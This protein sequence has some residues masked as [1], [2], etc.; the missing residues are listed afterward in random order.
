MDERSES[1]IGACGGI[2]R[3]E[4]DIELAGGIGARHLENG[5]NSEAR[6]AVTVG[7]VC[8]RWSPT[9]RSQA[10]V[11]GRGGRCD[12]A[13]GGKMVENAGDEVLRPPGERVRAGPIPEYGPALGIA[14]TE[15]DMNAVAGP[16]R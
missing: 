8:R 12:R 6:V 2:G 14:E 5:A 15:M 4:L 10:E 11:G 13:K 9:V 16:G 3:A 1:Q 7:D